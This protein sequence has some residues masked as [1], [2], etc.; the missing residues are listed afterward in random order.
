MLRERIAEDVSFFSSDLYAQVC[1]GVIGTPD[2]AI[3]IDTLALPVET[4]EIRDYIEQR[5]NTPV[6]FVINT[7]HHADHSGGNY[8]FPDAQ[9]I[10]QET[11]RSLMETKGRRALEAAKQENKDLGD[12]QV[13]LPNVT[14]RD[15]SLYFLVGKRT[16]RIFPLPGHT[17]DG[18]GVLLE[19]E[20]ILFAGDAMMPLPYFRDGDLDTLTA[21][22]KTING[23]GLENIV[24]GHGDVILRGEIDEMI[25][26]HLVYLDRIRKEALNAVRWNWS[27]EDLRQ[28][29]IEKCGK[30]RILL[31]GLA[32][33]L[34]FQNLSAVFQKI[35]KEEGAAPEKRKPAGR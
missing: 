35:R 33:D 12:A 13:V 6:R 2:G 9:I 18:I 1:A 32:P 10:S 25:S 19:E 26:S 27:I 34:H 5:M 28:I 4:R 29:P 20:R 21:T 31:N 23:M 22:L 15:G 30:S 14:F 8:M 17:P 16:I 3:L 11:C 24:Q 7:H